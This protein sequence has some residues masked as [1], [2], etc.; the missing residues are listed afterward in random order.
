MKEEI[1][2]FLK[3][4]IEIYDELIASIPEIK[5]KGKNVPYTSLNGNMFTFLDK[6]TL[7]VRL[8]KDDREEFTNKYNS[9]PMVSYEAVMKEYVKIP[10]ELLNN[11][12]VLKQYLAKSFEYA[13]TLKPKATKK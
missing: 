9:E 11:M 2:S 6:G 8:S 4:K 5:R 3:E 1:N 13:K 7:A 12:D 10:D